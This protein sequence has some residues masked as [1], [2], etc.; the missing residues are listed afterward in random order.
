MGL[1][2][3]SVPMTP[4]WH[5]RG[6]RTMLF[7]RGP[8]PGDSPIGYWERTAFCAAVVLPLTT[9]ELPHNPMSSRLALSG[10]GVTEP[11]N[12]LRTNVTGL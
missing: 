3:G 5:G 7:S 8:L 6:S 9:P 1:P 12:H 4:T 10:V 2:I 11:D